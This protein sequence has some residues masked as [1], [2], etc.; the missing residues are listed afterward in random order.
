MET[1]RSATPGSGGTD[2][3][4]GLLDQYGVE[5]AALSRRQDRRR[6]ELMRSYGGWEVLWQDG[7]TVLL[8]RLPGTGGD[9]SACHVAIHENGRK[10]PMRCLQAGSVRDTNRQV[11]SQK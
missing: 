3:W 7:D 6:I 2:D 11:G 8:A 9:P 5:F 1:G 10:R 4:L